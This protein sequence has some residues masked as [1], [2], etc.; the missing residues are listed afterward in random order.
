VAE[1]LQQGIASQYDRNAAQYDRAARFNILAGERL[2]SSVPPGEYKHLLDVGCGTGFATLAAFARFPT[3]QSVVGVDISSGMVDQFR[4]K[5]RAH[6]DS[7]VQLQVA[8]VLAMDVPAGHFD[9]VI[10][11]MM[12][13]WITD[14]PGAL[15]VMAAA[16]RPGGVLAVVAPGP[17]HDQEYV[18]VLRAIRPPVPAPMIE[19]FAAAQVFP[20]ALDEQLRAAGLEP[21]DVWVETRRRQVPP[22][23]YM[24]RI[25]AVGSHVWAHLSADE[26]DA[27]FS[28]IRDGI[29]AATI[30]ARFCYTFTK[31]FAVARRAL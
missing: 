13:H 16:V 17:G 6:P 2:V 7:D 21:L 5:L 3:L 30:D 27:T 20:D 8:D 18:E 12:L 29:A 26:Q 31:S 22:E 23:V 1:I 4:E 25:T 14:R 28:R 19:V 15:R 9:L 24:E 11:S 10:S